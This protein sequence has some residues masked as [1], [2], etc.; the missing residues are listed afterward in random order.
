MI[1]DI[2]S[3]EFSTSEFNQTTP[4]ELPIAA[5]SLVQQLNYEIL[6]HKNRES[7]KSKYYPLSRKGNT[8]EVRCKARIMVL[9]C[10]FHR[11][12]VSAAEQ[13]FYPDEI[14]QEHTWE[15]YL[16]NRIQ[17]DLGCEGMETRSLAAAVKKRFS[18]G[19]GDGL[20]KPGRSDMGI[21][22]LI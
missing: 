5:S 12:I 9:K 2:I 7:I 13:G 21:E 18:I 1:R 16:R 20:M 17:A 6:D 14:I 8:D 22:T 10:H 3:P 19:D 4:Q 11:S 15:R